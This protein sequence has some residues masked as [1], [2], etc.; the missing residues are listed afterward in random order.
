MS[1]SNEAVKAMYQEA[2]VREAD[3]VMWA[4]EVCKNWTWLPELH[5]AVE[6][7]DKALTAYREASKEDR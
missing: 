1:H 5:K 3:V 7:Y 4:R 6:D 2:Q